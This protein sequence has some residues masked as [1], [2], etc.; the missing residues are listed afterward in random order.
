MKNFYGLLLAGALA[1]A[2]VLVNFAYLNMKS[3]DVDKIYFIGVA[4]KDAAGRMMVVPQGDRLLES[5][6]VPVGIPERWTGDLK[7]FAFLYSA[8]GSVVGE[9]VCRAIEGGSLL[10]RDD[11]RTPPPRELEQAEDELAWSVPVDSRASLTTFIVPGD[12][13]S[14]L[15]GRSG[16]PTPAGAPPPAA[17]LG[18]SAGDDPGEVDELA[19]IP[20]P[21]PAPPLRGQ[22]EMIGP[23]KVLSVGA[24]LGSYD[25][26]RS[27]GLRFGSQNSLTIAVKQSGGQLE[28]KAQKLAA[29]LQASNYQ[30][31]TVFLHPR[32]KTR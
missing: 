27:A 29:M 12:M 24:R 2:G 16:F 3:K 7:D 11:L 22:P 5:D 6:L 19:P 32:K 9:R 8:K 4:R 1:L 20:Q 13:V 21:P 25:V 17:E 10:L 14:F 28:P 31:V 18:S 23:F 15:V 30:H 26:E